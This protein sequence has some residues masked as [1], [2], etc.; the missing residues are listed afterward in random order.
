MDTN[1]F[2]E[3]GLEGAIFSR[4]AEIPGDSY[5][6][7]TL[8]TSEEVARIEKSRIFMKSWLPVAR[9]EELPNAGD[10]MTM[11]ITGEPIVISHD[12][13]EGIVAFMNMCRH[14]G[15]EVAFGSGNARNFTCLY[16]GW[17]YDSAGKL[18]GAPL[19]RDQGLDFERCALPRL[20]TALW[21]GWIFVNFDPD[22]QPFE[23][24][25]APFEDE[26]W[27]YRTGE[28]RIVD[29]LV[30]D[31]RCNWKLF[32]ENILDY[33]HL[34]TVHA[35]S[36][37]QFYKLGRAPLP[38]KLFANGGGSVLFD[39]SLR[40]ADSI[41]PFPPL[42]WLKEKAFS[43]KGMMF[44]N[45]NFWCGLDSLRMWHIWPEGVGHTRVVCYVLMPPESF[46]VPDFAAKLEKYRNYVTAIINEDVQTLQ[47]LQ[48]A[49]ESGRF[50]P[51]PI[52]H[53]EVMVQ[54][55]MRHYMKAMTA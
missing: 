27:Y 16:H 17:T 4:S 37:G 53:L 8:Y 21:R 13:R 46:N 11:R 38:V 52:T 24:Y 29:K 15:I 20:K 50:E 30:F 28:C 39:S 31:V 49:T 34:S 35:T 1:V 44:P 33:Y 2:T 23:D 18:L 19:M 47:S 5:L 14:R 36:S 22:A 43:A 25:I 12:A 26:L 48:L 6:P 9:A 54:H 51:G 45:V 3:R 55:L 7:G 42:P 10:Y 32:A 40:T 41:L